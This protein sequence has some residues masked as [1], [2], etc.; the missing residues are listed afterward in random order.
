[1]IKRTSLNLDM[2]LVGQAANIL[3]TTRTTDT[4]NGALQEIVDRDLRQRVLD[5][6]FSNL[7]LDKIKDI[8]RG[9]KVQL[10]D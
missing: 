2:E 7:T 8:R 6:D 3:G 1:M 4:V 9:E 10:D 5:H